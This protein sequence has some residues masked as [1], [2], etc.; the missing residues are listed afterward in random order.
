MMGLAELV[1]SGR[2]AFDGCYRV[3]PVGGSMVIE[4]FDAATRQDLGTMKKVRILPYRSG[5][6]NQVTLGGQEA[7]S[8]EFTGCVMT[9]FKKDGALTA[10]HVDTNTDTSQRE[11]Y[12]ALMSASGNELVADYDTTGKLTSYPGV[13][14]STLL[15]C[16]ATSS[17]VDHYFV[18]K[19]S[20]GV[21]KNIK[22]NPMMGTSGGWQVR[23][24]AVYTVL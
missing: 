23:N 3:L 19:S 22:A 24:E 8:G 12:A 21:S 16:V 15:F 4:F 18:S 6:I 2:P 20:L 5:M 10:G 7:I 17:E 14:G 1:N 9:L 13:D 11:A